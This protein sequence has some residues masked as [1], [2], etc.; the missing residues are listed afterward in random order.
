MA[1]SPEDKEFIQR[2]D[3]SLRL[4][5]E[6]R[7]TKV[8]LG[9]IVSALPV[10]FF[11]GGI[12]FEGKSAVEMLKN[13]QQQA[14]ITQTWMQEREQASNR[15]EEWAVTKGYNPGRYSPRTYSQIKDRYNK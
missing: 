4:S 11:L 1:L 6:N 8:V 12:Y 15:L 7:L 10:I 14:A 2:E 13:Q 9:Q 5:L 3:A